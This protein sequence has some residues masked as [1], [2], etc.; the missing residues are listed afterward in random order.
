MGGVRQLLVFN[1][2]AVEKTWTSCYQSLPYSHQLPPP[3]PLMGERWI[4]GRS[5]VRPLVLV[6][7]RE[8]YRD[9]FIFSQ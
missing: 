6:G 5:A 8:V 9:K 3:P 2:M 7:W 1:C 4:G